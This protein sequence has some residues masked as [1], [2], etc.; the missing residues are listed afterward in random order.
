VT[1]YERLIDGLPVGRLTGKST[2]L[3]NFVMSDEKRKQ[4][5]KPKSIDLH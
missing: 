5:F 2:M 1:C 3:I 4:K